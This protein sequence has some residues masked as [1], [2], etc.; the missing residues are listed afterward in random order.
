[1]LITGVLL[2]PKYKPAQTRAQKSLAQ[3]QIS[4]DCVI[5]TICKMDN[6]FQKVG[7][8]TRKG[9]KNGRTY[10]MC[11]PFASYFL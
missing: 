2:N 5:Q 10:E 11:L 8:R 1:M 3:A 4:S 9:S 6:L 7:S